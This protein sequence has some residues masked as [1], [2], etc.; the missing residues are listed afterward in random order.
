MTSEDP[1]SEKLTVISGEDI[2]AIGYEH[3]N[4]HIMSKTYESGR[5][6]VFNKF[7]RLEKNNVYRLPTRADKIVVSGVFFADLTTMVAGRVNPLFFLGALSNLALIP[8]IPRLRNEW[9][10]D[11]KVERIKEYSGK[12]FDEMTDFI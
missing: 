1:L 12:K 10:Y 5:E 9:K 4:I 2:D 6:R 7:G 11:Q 3:G 8:S